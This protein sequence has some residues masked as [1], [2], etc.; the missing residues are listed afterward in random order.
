MQA[1]F[2]G[3]PGQPEITRIT[4]YGQLFFKDEWTDVPK[5]LAEKKLENHPHFEAKFDKAEI[6]E[7]A[8]IKR[9]FEKLASAQLAHAEEQNEQDQAAADEQARLNAEADEIADEGKADTVIDSADEYQRAEGEVPVVAAPLT[10]PIKSAF[11]YQAR[12]AADQVPAPVVPEQEP[13]RGPGR[14][15]KS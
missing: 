7:D 8:E 15:R 13:K 1:K 12:E 3:V 9:E 14:P 11:D 4:M 2:I 6:A 10:E 5:G